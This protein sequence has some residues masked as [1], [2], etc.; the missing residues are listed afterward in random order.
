V[1]IPVPNKVISTGVKQKFRILEWSNIREISDNLDSWARSTS[2][3]R[4]R[5]YYRVWITEVVA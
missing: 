1:D 5:K 4:F 3:F 2:R